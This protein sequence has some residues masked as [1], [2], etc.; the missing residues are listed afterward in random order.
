MDITIPANIK[1]GAYIKFT[2]KGNESAGN[3]TGDLY[4][5]INV[6]P[7]KLYER[8]ED[9]LYTKTSVSLFDMVL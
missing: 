3:H 5:H 9:H 4:I 2:G 6:I 7:S 8:K 1:S